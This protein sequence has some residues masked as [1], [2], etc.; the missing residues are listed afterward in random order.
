MALCISNVLNL[1][2][3]DELELFIQE[4][5][6]KLKCAD[7]KRGPTHTVSFGFWTPRGKILF[8][9]IFENKKI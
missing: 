2:L 7:T 5:E 9:F 1:S 8:I 3:L 6:D 4:N